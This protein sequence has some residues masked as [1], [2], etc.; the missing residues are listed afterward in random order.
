M[1]LQFTAFFKKEEHFFKITIEQ[2]ADQYLNPQFSNYIRRDNLFFLRSDG[3]ILRAVA[4]LG[5]G[6]NRGFRVL[7]GKPIGN[8]HP[9][10]DSREPESPTH[11]A[12][13][14]VIAQLNKLTINFSGK[15]VILYL[16]NSYSS[17]EGAIICNGYL[18]RYDVCLHLT[19]TDP[20]EYYD[21]FDGQV[22]I[23]VVHTA[24]VPDH[25]AISFAGEHHA[26]FQFCLPDEFLVSDAEEGDPFTVQKLTQLY[27]RG[28]EGR[29]MEYWT[30]GYSPVWQRSKKGNMV[31]HGT[32]KK[33]TVKQYGTSYNILYTDD[34]G[35]TARIDQYL[36]EMLRSERMA[37]SAAEVSDLNDRL[38]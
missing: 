32:S 21:I 13:K 10:L 4:V 28:I 18:Y 16:D 23:E 11:T 15:E 3:N 19:A 33:Y 1:A 2:F 8:I 35:E 9:R 25:K 30:P 29:M 5:S 31:L 26:L 38:R 6:N 20:E 7:N 22:Y 17:T 24:P 12:N 34:N 36:K 14:K 37:M 27:G